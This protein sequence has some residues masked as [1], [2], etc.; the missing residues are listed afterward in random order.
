M[1]TPRST[2]L[3]CGAPYRPSRLAGLVE[4]DKC[5][6]VSANA[7]LSDAEMEALYSKDYFHGGEYLDYGEEEKSLRENFRAR[8]ATLRKVAPDL[9]A[10]DL[11]EIG[12]A[13]GFF[14]DEVGNVVRAASGIDVSEHAVTHAREVLRVDARQGDY[15]NIDFPRKFGVIVMWDTIEHLQRPDLFVAKASHDLQQ[16]G[17]LALTTGD[18]DSLNARLRGSKWRM[19]HPPTH[20]HYFSVRSI[21]HLLDRHGF[22]TLH[23]SHPGISR[24]LQSIFYYVF[25]WRMKQSALYDLLKR[26]RFSRLRVTVNLFDI[27]YVIARKR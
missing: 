11:F 18:I 17:L 26:Q 16:G 6:F 10:R 4:C 20:L 25:A 7:D 3:V 23:V 22:D 2:C 21:K 1:G 15:L 13:Y 9:A 24:N 14:L 27:M 19:I 5:G 12:C 8:I